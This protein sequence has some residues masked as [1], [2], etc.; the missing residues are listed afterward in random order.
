MLDYARKE[1]YTFSSIRSNMHVFIVNSGL[2]IFINL[3]K[4]KTN[5]NMLQSLPNSS[6]RSIF[7][8]RAS[9]LKV[10]TFASHGKI[11]D[12]KQYNYNKN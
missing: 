9:I 6:Y 7:Y 12:M 4:P 11:D 3:L 5:S 2:A 1:W 8:N 10:I